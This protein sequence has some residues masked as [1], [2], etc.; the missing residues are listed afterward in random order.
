MSLSSEFE[1]END[2]WHY[3]DDPEGINN[4]CAKLIETL[5]SV[6]LKPPS[7]AMKELLARDE[8][9]WQHLKA[10]S[11]IQFV[12]EEEFG[13]EHPRALKAWQDLTQCEE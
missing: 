10:G 2:S 1:H 11:F 9:L 5:A 3:A 4:V 6:L 12:E 7:A 13:E 8:A